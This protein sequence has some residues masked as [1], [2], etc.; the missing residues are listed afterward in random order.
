MKKGNIIQLTII[1]T[2]I[3][4]G[5]EMLQSI[6][7]LIWYMFT[8]YMESYSERGGT[9]YLLMNI[10]LVLI[11]LTA[12]VLLISRSGKIT[13]Y[14][15]KKA[16]TSFSLSFITRPKE[17]LQV[18]LIGMGIYLL[19]ANFP[20]LLSKLI[21]LFRAKGTGILE[22]VTYN[23]GTDWISLALK[24]LLPVIL[25]VYAREIAEYFGRKINDEPI[26][27]DQQID[28]IV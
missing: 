9:G 26:T 22:N 8:I 11:Q 13:A 20:P 15:T 19:V 10:L 6:I 23:P 28:E 27:L 12:C 14:I 25:I 1:I 17:L 18:F 2:G 21:L 4:I 16:G 5:F 3:I 24:T 7:S